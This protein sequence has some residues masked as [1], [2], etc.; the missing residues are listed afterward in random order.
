MI[1]H[2]DISKQIL[3][4]LITTHTIKFGG[5][6]RLKIYGTLGCASGKRMKKINRVFFM[7]ETEALT[8]GYR[9]CVHCM[10]NQWS[11]V[12]TN[13]GHGLH[14]IAYCICLLPIF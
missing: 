1:R 2:T 11:G 6:V 9:P 5:N 3:R 13:A 10:K 4:D 12:K 8:A 7:D 14:Q